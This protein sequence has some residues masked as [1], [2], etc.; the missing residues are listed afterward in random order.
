M[1][2]MYCAATLEGSRSARTLPFA[3]PPR[4][5]SATSFI[6]AESVRKHGDPENGVHSLQIEINRSIYMDEDSYRRSE[7]FAEIQGHLSQLAHRLAD[8]ARA[9]SS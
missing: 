6:G 7:R 1:Y 5:H 4:T 3:T 9:Q 8:F 2:A